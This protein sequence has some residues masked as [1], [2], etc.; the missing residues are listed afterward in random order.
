L[1]RDI[2]ATIGVELVRQ[3]QHPE[4]NRPRR[5][6]RRGDPCNNA[7]QIGVSLCRDFP[8]SAESA[9]FALGGISKGPLSAARSFMVVR[10]MFST[11][12]T[13]AEAFGI[14]WVL[15]VMNIPDVLDFAN[16]ADLVRSSEIID[17]GACPALVRD[18]GCAPFSSHW[19]DLLG[20][21]VVLARGLAL[22]EVVVMIQNLRT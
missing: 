5:Y 1:L 12:A 9:T 3:L 19:P 22:P 15:H 11:D 2:V 6:Q 10:H 17:R 18:A 14:S 7:V 8:F 13:N 21:F 16:F 4:G 20:E